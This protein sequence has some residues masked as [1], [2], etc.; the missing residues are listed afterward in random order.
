MEQ[1]YIEN[2]ETIMR[3]NLADLGEQTIDLC[4]PV[5]Y[6]ETNADMH[7]FGV[8]THGFAILGTSKQTAGYLIPIAALK[9]EYLLN[10]LMSLHYSMAQRTEMDIRFDKA[11]STYSLIP[12]NRE[13]TFGEYCSNVYSKGKGFIF[14]TKLLQSAYQEQ[15]R[16]WYAGIVG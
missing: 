8:T 2:I 6:P 12:F 10:V 14:K 16:L 9:E 5:A 1:K 7:I 11:T 15:F 4:T 3:V 13:V